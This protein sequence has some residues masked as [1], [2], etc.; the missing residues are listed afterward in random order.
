[1]ARLILLFGLIAA[2]SGCSSDPSPT[3]TV[4]ESSTAIIEQN[5]VGI[6]KPTPRQGTLV[7]TPA[8]ECYDGPVASDGCWYHVCGG[9]IPISALLLCGDRNA[10][11]TPTPVPCAPCCCVNQVVS[12]P[13]PTTTPEIATQI[14]TGTRWC[15]SYQE[16]KVCYLT[17]LEAVANCPKSWLE[18]PRTPTPTWMPCGAEWLTLGVEPTTTVRPRYDRSG[19][20]LVHGEVK[21]CFSNR[22]GNA[23]WWEEGPCGGN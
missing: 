5:Y 13:T 2:L 6:T 4:Q 11:N 19:N 9:R 15:C 12:T 14:E 22:N 3:S 8:S 18:A 23:L 10:I 1:M 16:P 7:P 20:C 21:C 17:K